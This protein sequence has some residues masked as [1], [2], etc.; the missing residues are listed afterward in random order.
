MNRERVLITGGAFGIG[1]AM[2]ERCRAEGYEA[3]VIDREGDGI[4]AD[5]SD[6]AETARAL[7][8][9][10]R[11][12]PITRLVNNVGLVRPGPVEEQT[13]DDLD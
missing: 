1:Q 11:E 3:V 10:L 6:P 9:A 4:R 2:A 12:G 5:L 8:E 13:P 7:D